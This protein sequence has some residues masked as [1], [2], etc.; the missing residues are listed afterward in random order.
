MVGTVSLLGALLALSKLLVLVP[1]LLLVPF[2]YWKVLLRAFR[3]ES[4]AALLVLFTY[5]PGRAIESLWPWY[6]QALGHFVHLLSSVFVSGLGY[7]GNVNPTLTGPDLDVTIILGC[8]GINGIELFDYL[9]GA[10]AVLDW[11]RFHKGRL[12]AGYFLGL[13]A[14]LLGN[15][16]RISCLVVFGN[17]GF[18]QAV[19]RYH[20]SA[21]WIFFS[22]VFLIYL[23]L[24]YKWMLQG[25]SLLS[26]E[27]HTAS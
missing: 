6:G 21:G 12:L 13:F 22:I 24:T 8:S 11:N 20:I 3:A 25:K 16:L 14:M 9:F 4:V 19:A 10:M 5:F 17:R 2:S 23:S 18:A 26:T 1:S 27:A 15:A 7:V